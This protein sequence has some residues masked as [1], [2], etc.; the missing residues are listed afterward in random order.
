MN[1]DTEDL[2]PKLL[3]QFARQPAAADA[4]AFVGGVERKLGRLR[5]ARRWRRGVVLLLAI[6]LLVS[7]TPWAV[8]FSLS[9]GDWV[10]SALATPWTWMLSLPLGLWVLRRSRTWA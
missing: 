4:D 7:V 3:R 9:F 5:R 2:D 8:R 10:A 6:G 1:P